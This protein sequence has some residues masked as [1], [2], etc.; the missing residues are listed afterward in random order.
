VGQEDVL[1]YEIIIVMIQRILLLPFFLPDPFERVYFFR[2]SRK[3]VST[4]MINPNI[5]LFIFDIDT[6]EAETFFR[7]NNLCS[8]AWDETY[9]VKRGAIIASLK[10]YDSQYSHPLII[11]NKL[12]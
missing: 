9:W 12:L 3:K 1:K 4:E 8:D 5:P 2:A 6:P 11:N 7:I 10:K